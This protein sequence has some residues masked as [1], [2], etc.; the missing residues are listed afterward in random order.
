MSLF[1]SFEGG[2][3][4]GTAVHAA[5]AAHWLEAEG[6]AVELVT[7]GGSRL[8]G[9]QLPA[10]D[11]RVYPG[12]V[13]PVLWRLTDLA[14]LWADRIRPHLEAGGIVICDRYVATLRAHALARR[15]D[16]AWLDRVASALPDADLSIC[17]RSSPACQL[18]RLVARPKGLHGWESGADWGRSTSLASGFRLYAA[19]LERH[20][21]ELFQRADAAVL[22]GDGDHPALQEQICEHLRRALGERR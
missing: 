13:T 5:W 12:R 4:S 1:V 11:G 21:G 16:I 7:A 15:L 8:L 10:L 17:L 18:R 19:R 22:D 6:V 14:D 3:G 20:L 9:S 2:P